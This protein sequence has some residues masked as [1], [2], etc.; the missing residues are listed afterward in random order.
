[1][2]EARKVVLLQQRIFECLAEVVVVMII[3]Q[4]D[5]INS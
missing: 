1:M 5:M 4:I 3:V 2:L